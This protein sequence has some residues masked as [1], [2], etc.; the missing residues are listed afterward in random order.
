MSKQDYYEILGVDRN[1]DATAIKKAYRKKAVKYHPDKN[2]DNPEAEQKFKDAAE[3]YD[4]LSDPDKRARYD[5]FGHAG[6]D[7]QGGFS[8]G[9]GGMTMEDIFANFGDIFGSSGSPFDTFFGGSSGGGQRRRVEKGAN[10][11]IKVPMTLEEIQTGISKKIK[12]KKKVACDTCDGSGAKE[13]SSAS[14]CATCGGAGMVNQVR[15]TFLGRMQTTAAC[16]TCGGSGT[17]ITDKC[18][19]CHGEGVVNGEETIEFDI[20]AGV[21][22]QMILTLRGKGNAGR[23]D[24]VNGDLLINIEEKDHPLFKRDGANVLYDMYL[25]FADAA[26]GTE[27]EVP[28]LDGKVMIKVPAGTQSGKIFRLKGKGIPV[29]QSYKTGDQL[30]Y[31]NIW[32]PKKLN[33]DEK[34]LLTKLRDKPNMQ[35]N[36]EKGERGF[37]EKMKE[38]FNV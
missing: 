9:P 34:Q 3:A 6:V 29:L 7:G 30:I 25:N 32:T 36:P 8:G 21:Q 33:K 17:Q 15:D 18:T 5:R 27:I 10:I 16:P 12:V 38:Y 2:P 11:R 35:P 23:R 19:T 31:V 1:A 13:G 14:A 24:G 20:P 26:L 22:D 37:F 4:V 28:T